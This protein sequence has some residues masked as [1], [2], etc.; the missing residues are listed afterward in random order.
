MG[1]LPRN[2][3][4]RRTWTVSL[5]LRS[6]EVLFGQWKKTLPKYSFG[7]F[8]YSKHTNNP[9]QSSNLELD[10]A[11]RFRPWVKIG[12]DQRALK[13]C[14]LHLIAIALKGSNFE[15]IWFN[16]Q[17]HSPAPRQEKKSDA[18][19]GQEPSHCHGHQ[20]CCKWSTLSPNSR[21]LSDPGLKRS[22]KI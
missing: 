20:E 17:H 13:Y 15:V 11:W 14:L 16:F 1:T 10:L 22:S 9:L 6:K 7:W 5:S 12:P 8:F 18:L 19:A 21:D 2:M 4:I 3:P